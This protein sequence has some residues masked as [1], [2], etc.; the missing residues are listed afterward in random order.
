MVTFGEANRLFW[1][2]YVDFEGRSTPAEFWWPTLANTLIVI[3]LFVLL[4]AG[5]D[6]I[7]G[8]MGPIGVIGTFGLIAFFLAIFIP[9][10]SLHV[11]RLHD[12]N[13]SGWWYLV[14]LVVGWPASVVIGCIP[15]TVGRNRFGGDGTGEETIPEVFS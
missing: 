11:R 14:V 3:A 9:I 7:T 13:A 4:I 12:F 1:K 2:R 6:S 15:G 8:E 10:I 5:I